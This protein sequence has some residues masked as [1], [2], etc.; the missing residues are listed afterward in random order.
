MQQ[1]LIHITYQLNNYQLNHNGYFS[2]SL[3]PVYVNKSLN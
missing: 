1:L 2:T 3:S